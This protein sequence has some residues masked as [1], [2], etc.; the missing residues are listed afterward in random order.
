MTSS[1]FDRVRR[2]RQPVGEHV[3]EEHP[4]APLRRASRVCRQPMGPA[5][6]TTTVSP[7]PTWTSSWALMAQA[8]GSAAEASSKPM[9]SGIRLSPSTLSTCRGTIM[10][11]A[12]P[13]SYW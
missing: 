5:P 8:N 12:K 9:L 11:S 7:S 2:H 13:P 4:L 6:K 10:Y 3:D 1:G